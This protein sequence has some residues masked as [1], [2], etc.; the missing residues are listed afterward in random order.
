MYCI[1]NMLIKGQVCCHIAR[2]FEKLKWEPHQ[3]IQKKEYLVNCNS[4]VPFSIS[5]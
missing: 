2:G 5:V 3:V 4:F 1:A